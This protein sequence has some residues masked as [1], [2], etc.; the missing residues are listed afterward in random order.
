MLLLLTLAGLKILANGQITLFINGDPILSNGPKSL[1]RNPP[2]CIML[3]NCVF[4]NLIYVDVEF[5]IDLS[6]S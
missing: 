1:P 2:D 6:I 4:D 3:D 5:N